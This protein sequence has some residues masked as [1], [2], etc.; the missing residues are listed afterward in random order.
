MARLTAALLSVLALL[1][2]TS[3]AAYAPTAASCQTMFDSK[4]DRTWRAADG[5]TTVTL[6][7]GKVAWLFGD[8]FRVGQPMVRNSVLVQEG[9]RLT[10]TTGGQ[11]IPNDSDGSWYWPSD[12]V[13]DGGQL[14]VFAGRLGPASNGWASKGVALISFRLDSRGYPV[15][16]GKR[17]VTTANEDSAIQWG[18]AVV[19]SGSHVYVYGQ[20]RRQAPYVFGRDVYLA[21]VARGSLADLRA[22]RYWDGS[23]W[24]SRATRIEAAETGRFASAFSVDRVD[25]QWVAVSKENDFLGDRI[26]S[27]RSSSPAGPFRTVGVLGAPPVDGSFTYQARAHPELPMADGRLLV[28]WNLMSDDAALVFSTYFPKPK[29]G[30]VGW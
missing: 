10:S 5:N 27:M 24:S 13:W 7:N 19:R 28:T 11:A 8:T 9:D 4:T 15:Y 18:T 2:V 16:A 17:N 14:R 25:G 26:I 21:R 23:G 29:C 3:A 12:G 6:P 22:W 20:R 1:G 30:E